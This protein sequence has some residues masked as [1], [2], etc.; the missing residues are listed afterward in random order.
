MALEDTRWIT[1]HPNPS[2]TQDLSAI[3]EYVIAPSYD[4]LGFD[5]QAMKLE[6]AK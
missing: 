3:E 5:P 2:N 1:F 6:A 4:A